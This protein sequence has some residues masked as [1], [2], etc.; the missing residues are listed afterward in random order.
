MQELFRDW[1][2][3]EPTRYEGVS[4]LPKQLEP[5]IWAQEEIGMAGDDDELLERARRKVKTIRALAVWIFHKAAKNLPD[6]PDEHVAIDPTA[7]SLQPDRWEEDGLFSGDGLTLAQ[8]LEQLPG[9]EE[10]DL[11]ARGAVVAGL[12][13]AAKSGAS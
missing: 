2:A 10:M 7:I 8:A 1:H 12:T 4:V 3:L 11:E 9:I 5:Y 6:P 13:P